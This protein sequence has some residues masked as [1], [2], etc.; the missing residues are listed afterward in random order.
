MFADFERA[1]VFGVVES[2]KLEAMEEVLMNL[3]LDDV[4]DS[5]AEKSRLLRTVLTA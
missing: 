2:W 3:D 1:C 4:I 5:V